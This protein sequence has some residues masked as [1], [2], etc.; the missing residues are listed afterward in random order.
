MAQEFLYDVRTAF[1]N[2]ELE[3]A[4]ATYEEDQACRDFPAQAVEGV[5]LTGYPRAA[6]GVASWWMVNAWYED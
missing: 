5:E 6:A 1:A 2:D 3:Y 4:A